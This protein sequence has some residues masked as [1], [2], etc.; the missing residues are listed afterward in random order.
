MPLSRGGIAHS[1]LPTSVQVIMES[2]WS[3][4]P[5]FEVPG[6]SIRRLRGGY[7]VQ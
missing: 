2:G 1:F 3:L 4:V 6:R 7:N 5:W